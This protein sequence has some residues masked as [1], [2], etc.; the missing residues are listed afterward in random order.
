L[1]GHHVIFVFWIDGLVLRWKEDGVW[2]KR[3]ASKV[4]EEVGMG[5]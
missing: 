4:L 2:E 3:N 1:I 5:R